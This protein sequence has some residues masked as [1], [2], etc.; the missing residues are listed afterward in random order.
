[1][2]SQALVE[3]A[4]SVLG[5]D[6]Q[7]ENDGGTDLAVVRHK[8]LTPLGTRSLLGGIQC[9]IVISIIG[10]CIGNTDVTEAD[11]AFA[12]SDSIAEPGRLGLRRAISTAR[13][14]PGCDSLSSPDTSAE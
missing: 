4:F 14:G 7:S 10:L 3:C 5:D 11:Y 6:E 8:G 13:P 9:V 12:N 2:I 1:M